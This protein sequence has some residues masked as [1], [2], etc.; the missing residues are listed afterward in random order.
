VGQLPACN[1][2]AH[3]DVHDTL[4]ALGNHRRQA[5]P[6]LH[7]RD[8]LFGKKMRQKWFR[9]NAGGSYSVGDS[10]VDS[11]TSYRGHGMGGITDAQQ[12]GLVPGVQSV[13]LDVENLHVVPRGEG[14]HGS[15]GHRGG[16]LC[17][18]GV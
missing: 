17:P 4:D 15:L 3:R 12:P 14:V 13:D 6:A 18:E 8:V 1:H 16:D 10:E 11:D 7:G 9:E 2:A 5:A